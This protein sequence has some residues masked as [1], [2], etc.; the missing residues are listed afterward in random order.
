MI[1]APSEARHLQGFS[2]LRVTHH[3]AGLLGVLDDVLRSG[4]V[5]DVDVDALLTAGR[6]S[7][8]LNSNSQSSTVS[9][10]YRSCKQDASPTPFP[11]R[12]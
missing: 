2:E 1:S 3:D 6:A 5:N 10:R 8:K 4:G 11:S 7:A 12:G 9:K